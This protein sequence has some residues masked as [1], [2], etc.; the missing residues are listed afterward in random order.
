MLWSCMLSHMPWARA[1][2]HWCFCTSAAAQASFV[3]AR[4]VTR[5]CVRGRHRYASRRSASVRSCPCRT[6]VCGAKAVR[7]WRYCSATGYGSR[8]SMD[9][10]FSSTLS[11]RL[12]SCKAERTLSDFRHIAPVTCHLIKTFRWSCGR[13]LLDRVTLSSPRLVDILAVL[14]TDYCRMVLRTH[15]PDPPQLVLRVPLGEYSAS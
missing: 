11:V 7:S 4:V 13:P 1:C 10:A 15:A 2:G 3:A 6:G 9:Y 5:T 8:Y 12:Y 14:G